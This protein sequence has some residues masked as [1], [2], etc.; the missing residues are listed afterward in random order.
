MVGNQG[1][2]VWLPVGHSPDCDLIADDGEALLRVQVKTT[3]RFRNRRWEDMICTRGSNQS[4][5]SSAP[6]A[7]TGSLSSSQ[8]GG[9]GSFRRGLS[10]PVPGCSWA[11]PST[12]SSRLIR[13][14][15]CRRGN[16]ADRYARR[17]SAGFPSG[18]R[19]DAVNVAAQ[20]SQVRILPPPYA[21][22]R[23]SNPFSNASA[24]ASAPRDSS[25]TRTELTHAGAAKSQDD[26]GGV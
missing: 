16:R 9:G 26:L 25:H 12:P 22:L 14:G 24:T 21:G 11:A 2:G 15:R 19:D 1:Y 3:M 5:S 6:R 10:R 8:T 23:G 13:G 7:A 4:W 17:G 18:Q 20:P